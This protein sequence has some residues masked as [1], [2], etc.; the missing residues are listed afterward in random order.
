M[1][2]LLAFIP[3]LLVLV[4]MLVFRWSSA[5]AGLAGW[6]CELLV[7]LLAFGLNWPVFWVSQAK[8][9]LLTLNV[10]IMLWPAIF[11]YNLVDQIGGIQAIAD[12]LERM[13]HEKGWL[14]ILQAWMLSTILETI[15]GFGIPIAIVAPL[16]M[17]LGVSPVMAVAAVAVGHTWASS[18]GGMALSLRTLA[19]I[20]HY[21]VETLYP[22]SAILLGLS[23]ILTGLAVAFLLRQGQHWWRV[24]IVGSV[25]AAAHYLLGVWGLISISALLAS[26]IG[27]IVGAWITPSNGLAPGSEL[28]ESRPEPSHNPALWGGLVAYGFLIGIILLVS[29]LAPLN[30]VLSQATWTLQFPSVTT[31]TGLITPAESGYLFHIFTH[32]GSLIIIAMLFTLVIFR[33]HPEIPNPDLAKL[34]SITSR[35]AVPASLGTLTMIGLAVTMEHTGMTTALANGM[36]ALVG[37]VYPLFTPI[38]GVI[39]SFA[40]GSNLNSNVLFGVL[41]KEIAVLIGAS[42]I[43]LLAAQTTGASLGSMIAPAKLAVGTST[44]D[45]KGREGEVLRYTL[46]ICLVIAL[47]IGVAALI[48]S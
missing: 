28:N 9:L 27:F 37:G 45:V 2:A 11:M 12:A 13:V 1:L 18:T 38:I 6:C 47:L 21:P 15:T 31:S 26:I 17:A 39:G 46:P 48:M 35:S 33:F 32:P 5:W 22:D 44:S 19:E 10:L 29:L 20:T 25:A 42:P 16:M 40:T 3:I 14:L 8:G 34:L 30:Q 41:Q 7:A 36:G 23:L 24:L 43:V 4:L